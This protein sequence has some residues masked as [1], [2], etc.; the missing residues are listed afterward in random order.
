MQCTFH[1]E[2]SELID[3]PMLQTRS[4]P[5]SVDEIRSSLEWVGLEYDHGVYL[6]IKHCV[7]FD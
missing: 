7:Q 2:L 5:G 3:L 6:L 4:V 1:V